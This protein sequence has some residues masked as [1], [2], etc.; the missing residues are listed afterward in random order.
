MLSK[1]Y[2]L[3]LVMLPVVA[4]IFLLW[5]RSTW[6][7]VNAEP[8]PIGRDETAK[9]HVYSDDAPSWWAMAFT[10]VAD[11]TLFS[12]LLFGGL[13][14]WVS[15]P[16]WPTAHA[17]D[18]IGLIIPV[19][20]ITTALVTTLTGRRAVTAQHGERAK[21]AANCGLAHGL[22]A[23]LFLWLALIPDRTAHALSATTFAVLIYAAIHHALG[24]LFAGYSITC[25]RA[26]DIEK[27]RDLD[28]KIARQWHDYTAAA[29]LIALAFV[30]VITRLGST[31]AVP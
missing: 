26:A 20:G 11:A 21:W 9:L 5:T 23:A 29:A 4:G 12:S 7:G 31:G 24:V 17:P 25:T 8:L 19:L 3:A 6:L 28:L 16:G 30:A 13:F 15:A 22:G 2:W 1:L 14:L 27:P 18:D 10:L